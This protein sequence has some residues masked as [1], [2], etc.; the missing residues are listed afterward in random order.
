MADAT[1]AVVIQI[2]AE[3]D[4]SVDA[5]ANAI[6]ASLG[7]I[8]TGLAGVSKA[9]KLMAAEM[10]AG[11]DDTYAATKRLSQG[12]SQDLRAGFGT[13]DADL[14]RLAQ[15]VDGLNQPLQQLSETIQKGVRY[16]TAA[17]RG[18]LESL[19]D[20]IRTLVLVQVQQTGLL[21]ES[22]VKQKDNLD[23]VGQSG[24]AAYAAISAVLDGVIVKAVA[25]RAE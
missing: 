3:K 10:V 8:D 20:D 15:N 11:F 24:T 1:R 17:L 9:V 21:G 18:E 16:Q 22:L 25:T 13:L 2:R 6:A 5:A 14:Q 23:Q 12:I 4:A 19:R 7:N